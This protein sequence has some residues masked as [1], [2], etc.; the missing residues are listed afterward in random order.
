M[1]R[2]LNGCLPFGALALA[3]VLIWPFFAGALVI[4]LFLTLWILGFGMFALA[5]FRHGLENRGKYDLKHLERVHRSEELRQAE[6]P[7]VNQDAD[8]AYCVWC[9]EAFDARLPKCPSC[10]RPQGSGIV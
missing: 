9:G 8:E 6:I 4:K 10:C 1:N 7:D 5:K 2:A 3:G